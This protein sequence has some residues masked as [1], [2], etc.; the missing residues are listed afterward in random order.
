MVIGR[1]EYCLWFSLQKRM[2]TQKTNIMTNTTEHPTYF[3]LSKLPWAVHSPQSVVE[4]VSGAPEH[5]PLAV[6]APAADC[7]AG[8]PAPVV[9]PWAA[10][11]TLLT[12]HLDPSVSLPGSPPVQSNGGW[13]CFKGY[14]AHTSFRI[15]FS[16]SVY[17]VLH[18][19]AD[20][21][22]VAD[23]EISLGFILFSKC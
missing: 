13:E 14:P 11:Q 2:K 1:F 5:P 8:H 21:L 18:S 19:Y 4:S 6:S 9:P 7:G 10:A 16:Y 23:L 22:M 15:R 20:L 17:Q 12:D 3:F